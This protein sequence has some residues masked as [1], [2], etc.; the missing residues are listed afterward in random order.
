[1]P[2]KIQTPVKSLPPAQSK[3]PAK[4]ETP[5][6]SRTPATSLDD[7]DDD[8]ETEQDVPPRKI[9]K[10]AEPTPKKSATTPQSLRVSGIVWHEEPSRRLAVINGMIMTEGS[11]FEGVKIEEIHPTGIRLSQEG[12]LFELSLSGILQ[13]VQM[14]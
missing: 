2:A 6:E 4:R 10:T 9:R 1:V 3:A 7:E 5:V 13:E 14:K 12:R 8:D 11:V